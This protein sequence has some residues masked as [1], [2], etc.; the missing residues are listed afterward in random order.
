MGV[1]SS[2]L[3]KIIMLQY[4]KVYYEMYFLKTNANILNSTILQ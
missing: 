1:I 2:K 3:Y 4:I